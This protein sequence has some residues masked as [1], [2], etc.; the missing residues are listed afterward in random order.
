MRSSRA[1]RHLFWPCTLLPVLAA[2]PPARSALPCPPTSA[3]GTNFCIRANALAQC[4][5]F[6]EYTITEDYAL[7]MELKKRGFRWAGRL[8]SEGGAAGAAAVVI[9]EAGEAGEA[10]WD[11]QGAGMQALNS[12]C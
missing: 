2:H 8:A 5:W 9:G 10:E 11:Q 12:T 6:P 3:T 7:S 1:R 4:G